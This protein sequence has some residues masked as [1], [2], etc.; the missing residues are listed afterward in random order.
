MLEAMFQ[1]CQ[2]SDMR[3]AKSAFVDEYA[4]CLPFEQIWCVELRL[5]K[6]IESGKI[7]WVF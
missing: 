4:V 2:M 1:Q 6:W 7:A 3:R 5:G